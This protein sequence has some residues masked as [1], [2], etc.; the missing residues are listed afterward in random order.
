MSLTTKEWL[1]HNTK[2]T[3]VLITKEEIQN[4]NY[5]NNSQLHLCRLIYV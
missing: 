2:S 5:S 3:V 1:V 4:I